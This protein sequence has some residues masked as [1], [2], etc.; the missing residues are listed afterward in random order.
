MKEYKELMEAPVYV[1]SPLAISA[2]EIFKQNEDLFDE[3]NI[4]E[5]KSMWLAL[6]YCEFIRGNVD[7]NHLKIYAEAISNFLPGDVDT[8]RLGEKEYRKSDEVPASMLRLSSLGLMQK[9]VKIICNPK[10][11]GNSFSQEGSAIPPYENGSVFKYTQGGF[12][13]SKILFPSLES[14]DGILKLDMS[15]GLTL[16]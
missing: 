6:V 2:T 4:E 10:D 3:E 7:L 15:Q 13:L 8:L 16:M 5:D 12:E 11:V 9:I 1:D 14:D